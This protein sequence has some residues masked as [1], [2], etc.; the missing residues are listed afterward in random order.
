[1]TET[2]TLVLPAAWPAMLDGRSGDVLGARVLPEFLSRQRWYADKQGLATTVTF[3]DQV[4][5]A[6]GECAIAI[7]EAARDGVAPQRYALPLT[8][9]WETFADDPLARLHPHVLARVRRGARSGVLY[10]ASG[11]D[12]LPRLILDAVGRSRDLASAAGG[13]LACRPTAAFAAF[14]DV[15]AENCRRLGGEQSNTAL[16]VDERIIVKLYRRLQTGI[17]PEIEI[18]RFLTDVAHYANAP[19][20]LGSVEL[21]GGDGTI[22]AVAVIQEFVR[23]QGDGWTLTQG[24]LDRVLDEID[25]MQRALGDTCDEAASHEAYWRQMEVLAGRIGEL[26]RALAGGVADP[27]FAPEPTGPADIA[28]WTDQIAELAARAR[29]VLDR[30]VG[31][32][33]LGDAAMTPSARVLDAW[34]AIER[35]GVI[36]AAALAGTL[37]TRTHGDL[38]LGQVVAAGADFSILDFEGEPLHA[39]ERRRAKT[40]PLRDVAGMI[41]SFDYAGNAALLRRHH[42]GQAGDRAAAEHETVARWRRETTK[43][44]VAAYRRAVAGCASVPQAD[45]PFEAALAAFVLE[46][47]LYEVCYEAANRPDWLGIPLGGIGRLLDAAAAPE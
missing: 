25:P 39:L 10:D 45:A 8:I 3:A 24:H 34:A 47:A 27:A 11:S 36:P 37:K 6:A 23:N 7:I 33:N 28:A 32:G 1:M 13:R 5:L 16:L 15:R 20:L 22:T 26:H 42:P 9:A 17:H 12:E 21:A 31:A 40:S 44:F 14:R 4:P 2:Q 46:K 41:R 43:R 19:R 38:H 29:E 35:R 30:A 18:G